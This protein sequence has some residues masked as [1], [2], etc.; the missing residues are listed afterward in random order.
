MDK[1][2]ILGFMSQAPY[3]MGFSELNKRMNISKNKR[4]AFK[5]LL[6]QMEKDG[7]LIVIKGGR[8]GLPKRMN[9]VVGQIQAHPDGYGFLIPDQAGQPD[10]FINAGHMKGVWDGDRVVVR[11]E[12]AESKRK[13]EGRVIRVLSRKHQQIIGRYEGTKRFGYVV[14]QEK[15]LTEDIVIP[16]NQRANAKKGDIVVTRITQHPS[17]HRS[18][19]GKVIEILGKEGDQGLDEEIIIRNRDLPVKF[20]EECLKEAKTIPLEVLPDQIKKRLDLRDQLA[21]TI[22]GETAHDFDDAVAIE[23]LGKGCVRLWIHIADVSFYVSPN[24]AID[25]EAY[26]R[27]TSVYFPDRVLPML[28]FELSSGICSLKPD[29]NRLSISVAIDFGARGNIRDYQIRETVI[30]SKARLTYTLCGKILEGKASRQE[31]NQWRHIIPSLKR[32]RSLSQKLRKRRQ[33]QGSLDFDLPEPE[34]ILDV[35]GNIQDILKLQRNDS[36]ILIE[37]FMLM[38]NRIVATHLVNKDYPVIFRIHEPPDEEKLAG[39][40]ESIHPLGYS[41]PPPEAVKAR[42]LQR[43]LSLAKGKPEEQLLNM[44]LLRSM[45]RARYDVKNKGHF[46][47]AMEMYTHFTSPIRRYPDLIVHRLLR[48]TWD[49]KKLGLGGPKLYSYLEKASDHTSTRERIAEEA[50]REIVDLKRIRYMMNKLGE[51]YTGIIS[52]VTSFGIFVELDEIF[53]EGLVHISS[54]TDDF[55]HFYDTSQQL[56]GERTQ[57]IFRLGDR[58]KI[59]VEKVDLERRQIDFGLVR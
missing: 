45:K 59:R 8:Y 52:G 22:D 14:P 2:D 55:Y 13:Q 58:V 37:E 21:F 42:D 16:R 32:M 50:E 4:E 41:L 5:K 36:H 11:V 26:Q 27:A 51:E 18:P 15:R 12:K 39:L 46:G 54:I 33:D 6:K 47:L 35:S 29:E 57:N 53:V 20:P 9:L 31:K 40:G 1:E 48:G 30:R 7:E 25:K 43:I 10:V 56:I 44:L 23:D 19:V 34:I 17:Q 28:P 3:P 38:A 24:T 49:Q